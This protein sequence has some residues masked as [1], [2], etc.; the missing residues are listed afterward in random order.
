MQPPNIKLSMEEERVFKGKN[1]E[2]VRRRKIVES[3]RGSRVF[4]AIFF[5]VLVLS[6]VL[7]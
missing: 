5:S 7:V 6:C 3:E 1:D 2:I 4:L